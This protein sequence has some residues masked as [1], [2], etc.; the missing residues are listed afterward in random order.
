MKEE[1]SIL[2]SIKMLSAYVRL[3]RKEKNPT[4]SN[5]QKMDLNRKSNSLA[6]FYY[7]VGT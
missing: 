2:E 6:H 4:C 1:Y 3:C 7:K 5:L